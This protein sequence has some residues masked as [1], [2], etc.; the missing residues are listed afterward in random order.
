MKAAQTLNRI[1]SPQLIKIYGTC[2]TY[3]KNK[4]ATTLQITFS[5][6]FPWRNIMHVNSNFTEGCCC[7]RS[8]SQQVAL[9][10]M[11]AWC[12]QAP[13]PDLYKG[14]TSYV[15]LCE[16]N[17]P[18]WVNSL[19][20]SYAWGNC[21]V[22]DI[23]TLRLR[24]NGRHWPDNIFQKHSLNENVLISINVSLNFVP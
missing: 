19:N 7:W 21:R 4:M 8:G 15:M 23:N 18:Q 14:W 13:S 17:G 3:W 12:C 22:T 10:E 1:G 6:V 2:L 24:Q 20:H 9:V 11:M 5:N 16:V